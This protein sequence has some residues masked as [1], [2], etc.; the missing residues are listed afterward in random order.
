MC[1]FMD[2]SSRFFVSSTFWSFPLQHSVLAAE[3]RHVYFLTI[4]EVFISEE[5]VIVIYLY[6]FVVAAASAMLLSV[7]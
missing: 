4:K 5:V 2:F 1:Y 6:I 7:C 3:K